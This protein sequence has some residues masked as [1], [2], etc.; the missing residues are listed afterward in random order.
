M[1]RKERAQRQPMPKLRLLHLARLQAV[2][3]CSKTYTSNAEQGEAGPPRAE[4]SLEG[5]R[6]PVSHFRPPPLGMHKQLFLCCFRSLRKAGDGRV[7]GEWL[8]EPA[9]PIPRHFLHIKKNAE[10]LSGLTATVTTSV[11]CCIPQGL[12]THCQ[13][14]TSCPTPR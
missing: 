9:N 10:V 2:M 1:A 8:C 11:L 4:R 7:G 5:H 13:H 6:G 3:D 12:P 14:L